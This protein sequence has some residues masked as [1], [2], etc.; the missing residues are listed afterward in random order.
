MSFLVYSDEDELKAVCEKPIVKQLID[1][2]FRVM[3]LNQFFK[4]N[5]SKIQK[6][7]CNYK[8]ESIKYGCVCV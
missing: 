3:K 5:T 2:W 4:R 8:M 1:K 6:L 7:W